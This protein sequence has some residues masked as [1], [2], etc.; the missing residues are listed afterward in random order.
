MA[1][2]IGSN[3]S[4]I[5]WSWST[6]L[7]RGKYTSNSAVTTKL[8]SDRSIGNPPNGGMSICILS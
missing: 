7:V 4:K 3:F 8:L 5:A 1:K 6:V 2:V